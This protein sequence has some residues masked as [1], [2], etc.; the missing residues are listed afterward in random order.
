MFYIDWSDT[1]WSQFKNHVSFCLTRNVPVPTLKGVF[2][3]CFFFFFF[4]LFFFFFFFRGGGGGGGGGSPKRLRPNL[5]VTFHFVWFVWPE[6]SQTRSQIQ[7]QFVWPETSQTR[8]QISFNL[9]GPKRPGINLKI[10]LYFV[11]SKT[12]RNKLKNHVSLCLYRSRF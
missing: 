10:K 4:L 5:Q 2:C 1:S 9:S 7:F 3:C 8:F 12:S 11:W 6:T